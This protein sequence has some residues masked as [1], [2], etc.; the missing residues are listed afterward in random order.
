MIY[1]YYHM[2]AEDSRYENASFCIAAQAYSD[3]ESQP[4]IMHELSNTLNKEK[5]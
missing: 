4:L 1:S 3:P 5:G 2:V